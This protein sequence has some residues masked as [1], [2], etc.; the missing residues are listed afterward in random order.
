MGFRLFT[1]M[2]TLISKMV[3]S[4][5][6][7]IIMNFL[8][9]YIWAC[10]GMTLFGGELYESNPKIKDSGTDFPFSGVFNYNDWLSAAVTMFVTI[11][12]SWI[13][14]IVIACAMLYDRYSIPWFLTYLFYFSFYLV[15]PLM[16][17]N[18][19]ASLAIDVYT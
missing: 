7:V 1:D 19:F 2:C 16:A 4:C 10:A 9:I 14:E 18:T 3:C 15:S 12:N 13:D 5:F 17:F 11:L 6:Q 8:V